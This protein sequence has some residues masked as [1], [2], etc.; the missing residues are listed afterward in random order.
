MTDELLSTALESLRA[1]LADAWTQGQG[2]AI[3][4]RVSD[5][6]LTLDVVARKEKE[7]GGKLRWWLVEGGGSATAANETRQSLV[8]RLTP[9][10]YDASGASQPLDVR[11]TSE[12]PGR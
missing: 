1:E 2:H 9:G 12:K 7:G 10:L 5:I 4:F 3:R 11:G 6:T 8:L